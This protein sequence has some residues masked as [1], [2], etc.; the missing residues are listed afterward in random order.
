MK[1]GEKLEKGGWV[2]GL[3]NRS[4]TFR[5]RAEPVPYVGCKRWHFSS[6]YKTPRTANERRKS[7]AC[8][9]SFVRGK[10]NFMHLPNAYDDR[11]R[12]DY[13][14]KKSWK[15]SKIRKQWMKHIVG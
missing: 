12:S 10:R 11:T 14:I 13:Y 4:F 6:F 8:D 3:A 7:F 5:Y 1:H 9:P 15:K 2:I